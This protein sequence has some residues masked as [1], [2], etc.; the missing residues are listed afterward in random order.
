MNFEEIKTILSTKTIGIAGCGGL[1]SNCAVALAR[2]GVGKLI[3]VDFDIVQES[4]LNRQYYYNDQIGQ[5]KSF[6]LSDN[7]HFVNSEVK[8][9]AYDIKL[10]PNDIVRI[11]SDCDVI[12]EAFDLAEMK[13]MIIET[14]LSEMPEKPLICGVGMAGFGNNNSIRME[15]HDNLYIC[16]DF[17]TEIADDMPPMAPR[18]GIVANMQANQAVE[19]IIKK[20]LRDEHNSK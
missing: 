14:V 7:I 10:G 2:I 5:K 4:N 15:E 8:A 18:V 12:I 17:E 3:L 9:I 20:H 16:G 11:F 19:L 6:T 13:Q 1:G